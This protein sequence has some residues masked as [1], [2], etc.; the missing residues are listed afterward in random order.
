MAIQSRTS[1]SFS[2]APPQ[3]EAHESKVD[4]GLADEC[5]RPTRHRAI[6]PMARH[7]NQAGERVDAD[8]GCLDHWLCAEPVH[9]RKA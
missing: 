2:D 9:G 8:S 6:K 1:I 3:I 4:Q 5:R 7:K